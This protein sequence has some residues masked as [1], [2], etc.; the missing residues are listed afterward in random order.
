MDMVKA[1]NPGM[2]EI[3]KKAAMTG[4]EDCS[5]YTCKGMPKDSHNQGVDNSQ[6]PE[7]NHV[8]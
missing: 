1:M 4:K 6:V 2:M 7:D 8:H 3:F 5:K